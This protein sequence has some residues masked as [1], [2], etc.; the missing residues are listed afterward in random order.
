M[1]CSGVGPSA[2]GPAGRSREAGTAWELRGSASELSAI[3][4][5]PSVVQ[6]QVNGSVVLS[7]AFVLTSL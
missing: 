4:H 7:I 2:E 6:E 5:L 1:T 3:H